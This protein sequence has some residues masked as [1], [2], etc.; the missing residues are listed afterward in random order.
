LQAIADRYPE[1]FLAVGLHP[2]EAHLWQPRMMAEIDQL[3]A[4]DDRI[5]AIG[6]TGLDFYKSDPATREQQFAAFRAQIEIARQQDLALIVHC[7]EAAVATRQVLQEALSTLGRSLRVVMHCWSGT[8]QETDWFVDLGC[9]IS[10]SGIVTFKNA[11][12]VKQSVLRVPADQL[13]VET[14]CPF[15]APVPYR[16]KRN[17]PAYVSHVATM[18]AHLRQESLVD[19]AQQTTRNARCLFRLPQQP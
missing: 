8:P 7:R 12:S 1:V 4:S 6:E 5:V 15:L 16:G 13:L 14:D 3:A 18:V 9:Y 2:L 10:F 17:E 19:L 11:E